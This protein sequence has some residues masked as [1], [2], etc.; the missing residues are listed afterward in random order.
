MLLY[1]LILARLRMYIDFFA[2][3]CYKICVINI[4]H[5]CSNAEKSI[6]AVKAK[7]YL[8]EAKQAAANQ[9]RKYAFFSICIFI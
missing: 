6:D 7:I 1:L 2:S 4:E 8:G 5:E 3:T 9:N